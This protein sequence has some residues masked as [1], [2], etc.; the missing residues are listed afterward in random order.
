MER[1]LLDQL[2]DGDPISVALRG[3]A[4]WIHGTLVW[5]REDVILLKVDAGALRPETPYALVFLADVSAI[6]VPR[7]L[8]PPSPEPRPAGFIAR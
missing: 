3:G 6:G 8:T 4:G 7:E 1:R 2:A 5:R